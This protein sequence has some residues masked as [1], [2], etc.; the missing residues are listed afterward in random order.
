MQTLKSGRVWLRKIITNLIF[1]FL[2]YTPVF[3]LA[4]SADGITE[5]SGIKGGLIV[6][7]DNE[8]A[9]FLSGLQINNRFK[10]Q[11]L[12]SKKEAMK[13]IRDQL[14]KKNKYGDITT[15]F[16]GKSKLP[17]IDNMVNLLIIEDHK[18][19]DLKEIFRVITPDGV[20]LTKNKNGLKSTGFKVQDKKSKNGWIKCLKP[21]PK[22]MD[23][24]THWLHSPD[25]NAVSQD[26]YK[27]IPRNLQWVQNPLW[28]KSHELNM[29]L[30]AMVSA[31]GRLFYV[32]DESAPG[33]A[34]MPDRW[35]LIARDAF[36]GVQLWKKPIKEWGFDY[37]Q[38]D[39]KL[40]RT[41]YRFAHP[42]QILRRLIAVGDKVYFTPGLYSAV[43]EMDAATG[44]VIRTFPKTEKT[45][46][47]LRYQDKLFLGVNR[48]IGTE[49]SEPD[50][51]VMSIDLK[52][53]KK[54]WESKRG[55][56]GLRPILNLFPQYTDILL[57]AGKKAVFFVDKNEIIGLDMKT[58]K[59]IWTVKR[60]ESEQKL[61]TKRYSVLNNDLCN[62]TYNQSIL[63]FGQQTTE[64][65]T[66]LM[67]I[68]ELSGKILWE[69]IVSTI[70]YYTPPD[71]FVNE[72]LVWA[73]DKPGKSFSGLDPKTGEQ[74]KSIDASLIMKGTHHNCYMNKATKNFILYGRNKGVEFFDFNTDFAK[75]IN[76]FKGTCRYGVMPA[77]NML[78]FPSHN[79]TCYMTSKLNGI[80]ALSGFNLVDLAPSG[81]SSLYKNKGYKN[82]LKDLHFA[83]YCQGKSLS[84]RC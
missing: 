35:F 26:S 28:L 9:D 55:Y 14:Y 83:C 53:G 22:D 3:I 34:N 46:E 66:I 19:M 76:W 32:I 73:L 20:L 56:K 6:A 10:V 78:Y 38:K 47:I 40:A 33:I 79:C 16:L 82:K 48:S 13:K 25:N 27:E 51:S 37:W 65:T 42:R 36:N 39:L 49:N 71:I 75:R 72:G 21:R 11:G 64:N 43:S 58:G 45:F 12:N 31:K 69:K 80:A 1:I 67:A 77:N 5:F 41:A 30:S 24:W 74:K 44:K 81:S 2:F 59:K 57:T 23:E 29:S 15:K 61:F 52:T 50:I 7:V 63:F 84:G 60:P 4:E 62:L 17:Y 70:A 54:M 8:S 18:S 68:D